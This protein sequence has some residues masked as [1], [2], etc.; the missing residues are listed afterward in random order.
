MQPIT[1]KL[2]LIFLP[3]KR[4]PVKDDLSKQTM[5]YRLI[6]CYEILYILEAVFICCF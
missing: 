5:H 4:S 6:N 2:Q 1:N 3:K